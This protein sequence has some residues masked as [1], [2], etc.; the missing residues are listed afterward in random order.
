MAE[1]GREQR[2]QLSKVIVNN[3]GGSRQLKEFKDGRALNHQTNMVRLIQ[4]QP[5]DPPAFDAFKDDSRII[6]GEPALTESDCRGIIVNI[7]KGVPITNQNIF[8]NR[9]NYI[10]E[11]PREARS[12]EWGIYKLDNNDFIL[13]YGN[14]TAISLDLPYGGKMIAHSHPYFINSNCKGGLQWGKTT[15]DTKEISYGWVSWNTLIENPNTNETLKIFPSCEDIVFAA[16][17]GLS[18]H[19]VYTTYEIINEDGDLIIINPG[20]RV[21]ENP[22]LNFRIE[23]ARQEGSGDNYVCTLFALLD[24][25]N[26]WNKEVRVLKSQFNFFSNYY[27]DWK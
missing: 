1:Y 4:L 11:A 21:G 17:L 15:L 18:P 10:F 20:N 26:F 9:K 5:N 24:V 16:K 2:N 13:I 12:H 8:R 19:T 6:Y 25:Y 14:T 22:R 7:E 23:H 3:A 27:F